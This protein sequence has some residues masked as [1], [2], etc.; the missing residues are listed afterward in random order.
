MLA[1]LSVS[2]TVKL[3]IKKQ[4]IPVRTEE[5]DELT[6]GGQGHGEWRGEGERETESKWKRSRKEAASHVSL[7]IEMPG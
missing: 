5:A 3:L 7:K 4:G 1:Y 6:G 2:A